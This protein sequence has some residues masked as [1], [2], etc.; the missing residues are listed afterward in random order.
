[1]FYYHFYHHKISEFCRPISVKL[2]YV[3][4]IW[5]RFIMQ[6]QKFRRAPKIGAKNMK[7]VGRV[8]YEYLWNE[9]RYPK[10]ERHMIEN[11][12]SSRLRQ[13]KSGELWS[14]NYKV[15]H[16]SLDPLK[17]TFLGDY[18]LALRGCWP[19]KFLHLLEINEGLLVQ[20]KYVRNGSI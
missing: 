7:N 17:W 16:M 18:I 12:S 9:S 6:V 10:P 8:D 15:V 19:I 1:M 4:G 11:D 13:K 14:T 20:T 2:C 3:I 5:V